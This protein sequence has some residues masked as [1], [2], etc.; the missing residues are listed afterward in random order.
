V[1]EVHHN[2][3]SIPKPRI[4]SNKRNDQ[5][6]FAKLILV[7]AVHP[8][9]SAVLPR[10]T[11]HETPNTLPP[12]RTANYRPQP[13]AEPRGPRPI[14]EALNHL[15]ARRGYARIQAALQFDQAWRSAAG[16]QLALH[17]RPGNVKRGVLEITVRNSS[18]LQELTF[19]KKQLLAQLQ[20]LSVDP[21]I[22]DLRFR[23]GAID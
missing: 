18:V 23:I 22:R 6:P 4:A 15:L 5:T 12:R 2:A 9:T 8:T 19:Q 14:A 10:N 21:P 13:N 17:T 3:F 11:K 7:H 1:H 16:E 20:T